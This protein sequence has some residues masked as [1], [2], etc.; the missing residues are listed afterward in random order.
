MN[1]DSG[2]SGGIYA[3]SPTNM[4]SLSSSVFILCFTGS[5]GAALYFSSVNMNLAKE[6]IANCRIRKYKSQE[7]SLEGRR[8]RLWESEYILSYI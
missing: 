5:S 3:L 4:F 2:K 7:Q 8:M 1:H 6:M